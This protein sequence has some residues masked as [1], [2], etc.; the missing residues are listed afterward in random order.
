[1]G[2]QILSVARPGQ[3]LRKTENFPNPDQVFTIFYRRKT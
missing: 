2:G 1:M 3:G